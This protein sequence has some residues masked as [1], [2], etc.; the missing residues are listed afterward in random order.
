MARG[1]LPL[2]IVSNSEPSDEALLLDI[3]NDNRAAFQS[4]MERYAGRIASFCARQVGNPEVA[5]DLAQDVF[6]AVWGARTRFTGGDPSAWLFTFAVNR[7]RKH[8]RGWSRWLRI[9]S[10]ASS[11]PE[12]F[13]PTALDALEEHSLQAALNRAITR[14]PP[15][16]REAVL[17]RFEGQ[18]DYRSVGEAAGCTEGTARARTFDAI[19]SL[20]AQFQEVP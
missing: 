2:R 3:A 20:R 9:A 8:Q 5:E 14:L 7:C 16:Q 19:R 6:V 1:A 15:L 10:R 4:L 11:G 17:L 12:E 13:A 18:L